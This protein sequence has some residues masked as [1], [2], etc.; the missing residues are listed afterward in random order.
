MSI[1]STFDATTT[2]T[3]PSATGRRTRTVTPKAATTT[4]VKTVSHTKR[5]FTWDRKVVT[6]TKA[7]SCRLP[8]K[9]TKVDPPCRYKPTK[10]HS[11]WA[12]WTAQPKVNI[13]RNADGQFDAG[14]DYIRG[15]IQRA[16]ERR[17]RRRDVAVVQGGADQPTVTV[18]A[19]TAET[20][21]VC[22]SFCCLRRSCI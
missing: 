4:I 5:I 7:A 1:T 20:T 9:P 3:V 16:R 14:D 11:A 13:A 8:Q 10:S 22:C 2:I 15:A 18:T 21:T 6:E 19:P 12:H 17:A